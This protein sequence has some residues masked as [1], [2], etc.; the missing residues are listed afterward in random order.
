M[1]KNLTDSSAFT[2]PIVVPVDADPADAASVE[3]GFQALANRT[4]LLLERT[5]GFDGSDEFAYID[6]LGDPTTVS[7]TRGLPIFSSAPLDGW[8]FEPGTG[9]LSSL[10]QGREV[11]LPID[12]ETDSVIQ[13][14]RA[15]VIPGASRALDDNR[16][17]IFLRIRAADYSAGTITETVELEATSNSG[18]AWQ[19]ILSGNDAITVNRESTT[20]ELVIVSGNDA[21]SGHSADKVLAAGVYY[22]VP[23]PR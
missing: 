22:S 15:L 8:E 2:S 5:G 4:R 19:V 9:R 1:P 10:D 3:V 23:G 17:R 12:L 11:V 7:R 13:S 14:I 6:S 18:S 20:Y 21:P 16:M